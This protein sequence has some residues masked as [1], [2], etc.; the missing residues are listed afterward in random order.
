MSLLTITSRH[1]EYRSDNLLTLHH[2]KV[3]DR[4][5]PASSQ[6]DI[7]GKHGTRVTVRNLFGNLPVRVKQR[8]IA[9]EHKTEHHRLW[10]VLKRAVTGLM[11][12]WREPVSVRVR[13]SDGKTSI[14]L[15]NCS[16]SDGSTSGRSSGLQ[17]PLNVLTQ[18]SYVRHDDW[19]SWVPVSASTSTI[20]IKGAISLDPAPSKRVQF[21]SLGVTPLFADTGNNVL[22]DEINRLFALSSFGT[23]EHDATINEDEKIRRYGDNRYKT[24]GYTIRQLKARK[25][26]DRFPM[27]YLRLSL[28]QHDKLN[29]A[30]TLFGEDNANLSTVMD[31][32]RAM[33]TQWLA[34]HHF[35]PR[36][37]LPKQLHRP[38]SATTSSNDTASSD[39]QDRPLRPL[40]QPRVASAP[41]NPKP[42]EIDG[43]KRKRS[44]GSL[45]RKDSDRS[46]HLAFSAWSRIKSGNPTFLDGLGTKT[47]DAASGVGS[48]TAPCSRNINAPPLLAGALDGDSDSNPPV[49]D[50]SCRDEGKYDEAIPWIDP[51]TKQTYFVNARTGCVLPRPPARPQTDPLLKIRVSTLRDFNKSLRLP[52]STTPNKEPNTWLNGVLTAWKNPIFMPAETRIQQA[53]P[54]EDQ[55]I[56]DCTHS[57]HSDTRRGRIDEIFNTMSTPNASKLSKEGLKKAEVIAQ[58]DRKF[59]LVKMKSLKDDVKGSSTDREV[60]VLIDQHAADERLR[61][62]ALL[63][64]LCTPLPKGTKGYRSKLGHESRV[65]V[66]VLD[67]PIQFTSSI[68]EQQELMTHAP[69]FAAWG[70]LFDVVNSASSS[71]RLQSLLSVTAL[72]PVIAERC[73]ADPQVLITFLRTA[74]WKYADAEH[75]P[76]SVEEL[77]SRGISSSDAAAWVR[78]MSSCPEGLIDLLNSRACRSAIMFN[79]E[80]SMEECRDMVRRLC[81]CVFPFMCAHGRPSMVPLIDIGTGLSAA[82]ATEHTAEGSFVT[83]WK[84]WQSK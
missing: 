9:G 44:Q 57:N 39:C 69:R 32:L 83:A 10:D 46:H 26:V 77:D 27:F 49:T 63:A 45:P 72:P 55:Y 25:G 78:R 19:P 56:H 15:S 18:A 67:K 2:S 5:L 68:Q 58:L 31:V 41:P 52:K 16:Q 37:N 22:Y 35:Q 64:E 6:H 14:S 20:C 12:S 17:S 53:D 40:S 8:G 11:L 80:L 13:D 36:K 65:A 33:I 38:T 60:L 34:V 23:I 21:M 24:D 1:H 28:T 66:S 54:S 75:L 74:A 76:Q 84:R 71:T 79:D 48:P 61:V 50:V 3:I 59:I 4:Q 62:E 29:R 42:A 51:T 43:R 7:C 47:D 30:E 70:I 73:K 82:T 81:K